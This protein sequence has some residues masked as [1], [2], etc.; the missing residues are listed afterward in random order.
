MT[1]VNEAYLGN[2]NLKRS[3]VKHAWTQ[4]QVQEWMK[5]A[6]DPVYFI[7]EYIKIVNVDK[8]LVNFDLYDYQKR[9]CRIIS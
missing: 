5:C 3:N 6:K 8:G 7:E 1:K 2:Q 9:Y 4:E